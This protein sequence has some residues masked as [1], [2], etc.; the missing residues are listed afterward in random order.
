M[1]RFIYGGMVVR[2]YGGMAVRWYGGTAVRWYGGLTCRWYKPTSEMTVLPTTVLPTTVPPHRRQPYRRPYQL[3]RK[4]IGSVV[5]RL[6]SFP[7][8]SIIYKS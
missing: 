2:W 6:L 1:F 5:T 4:I 3:Q 8:R 7:D